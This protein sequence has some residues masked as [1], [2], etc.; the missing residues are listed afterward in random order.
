MTVVRAYMNWR[1]LGGMVGVFV[2]CGDSGLVWLVRFLVI[3]IQ[4]LSHTATDL[5]SDNHFRRV[6]DF[7]ATRLLYSLQQGKSP[8]NKGRAGDA[9]GHVHDDLMYPPR[10]RTPLSSWLGLGAG[11][12]CPEVHIC[13][14]LRG[15]NQ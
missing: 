6:T 15:C 4:R 2:Q 13:C 10:V 11:G 8:R 7:S 12:G 14:G 5:I 1:R 9:G 3:I